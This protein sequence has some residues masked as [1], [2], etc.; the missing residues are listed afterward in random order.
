LNLRNQMRGKFGGRAK[1]KIFECHQGNGNGRKAE[2]RSFNGG[3]DG[4]G[5]PAIDP[6]RQV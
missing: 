2:Q 6:S 1:I 5:V 3:G 4:S